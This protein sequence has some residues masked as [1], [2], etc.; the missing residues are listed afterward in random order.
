MDV[1]LPLLGQSNVEG[2]SPLQQQPASKDHAAVL[3]T[4]CLYPFCWYTVKRQWSTWL[5]RKVESRRKIIHTMSNISIAYTSQPTE[6]SFCYTEMV[7]HQH[8]WRHGPSCTHTQQW[9]LNYIKVELV[10]YFW[11]IKYCLPRTRELAHDAFWRRHWRHLKRALTTCPFYS[12]LIK[13]YHW[14][15]VQYTYTIPAQ[16]NQVSKDF[17]SCHNYRKLKSPVRRSMKQCCSLM[18][19]ALLSSGEASSVEIPEKKIRI[20]DLPYVNSAHSKL[21]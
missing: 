3:L 13:C 6:L 16:Q 5:H 14:Y 2:L 18:N 8:R 19:K 4:S 21:K 12:Y 7:A 20:L 1:H 17:C 10:S 11:L 9:R 15:I